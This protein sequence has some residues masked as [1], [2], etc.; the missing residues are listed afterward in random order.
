MEGIGPWGEMG[1][2]TG[3]SA[4]SNSWTS[5]NWVP[6]PMTGPAET[7]LRLLPPFLLLT[8]QSVTNEREGPWGSRH[9]RG[10]T[11]YQP[12][13]ASSTHQGMRRPRRVQGDLLM[14]KPTRGSV[15]ASQARPTNRMMEAE[16]GSTWDAEQEK[17]DALFPSI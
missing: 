4:Q 11:F 2:E 7:L 5:L 17:Y 13:R 8:S 1:P 9:T 14:Q 12:E 10:P 15:M 16:K 3:E 6:V